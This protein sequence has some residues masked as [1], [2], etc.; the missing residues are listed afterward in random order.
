MFAI[1]ELT[2][3]SF[4]GMLVMLACGMLPIRTVIG[5]RKMG[6][7]QSALDDWHNFVEETKD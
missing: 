1:G 6:D 3:F 4:V 5:D 2:D 7:Y